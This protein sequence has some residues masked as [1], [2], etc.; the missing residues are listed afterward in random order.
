MITLLVKTTSDSTRAACMDLTGDIAGAAVDPMSSNWESDT[1]ALAPPTLEKVVTNVAIEEIATVL[2]EVFSTQ[3][4]CSET[5][6]LSG[7]ADTPAMMELALLSGTWLRSRHWFQV[8]ALTPGP[9]GDGPW[10]FAYASTVVP[11][12]RPLPFV[13]LL[14]TSGPAWSQGWWCNIAS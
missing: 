11:S 14:P 2:W 5:P 12:V 7:S 10:L 13:T 4:Q 1:D 3:P 9:A 8:P 6:E